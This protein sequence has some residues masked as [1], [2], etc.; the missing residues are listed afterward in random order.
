M[1]GLTNNSTF[2]V[3]N[4]KERKNIIKAMAYLVA[5]LNDEE[6]ASSFDYYFCWEDEECDDFESL[7]KGMSAKDF[8]ILVDQFV[9]TMRKANK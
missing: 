9:S 4:H 1:I 6:Y 8:D 2:F 3:A 7:E 5:M